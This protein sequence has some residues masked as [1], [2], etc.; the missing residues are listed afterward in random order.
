MSLVTVRDASFSYGT[1]QIFH[2][3]SFSV[4]KGEIFC[5]IGPNGCGKTTL[6]D[7]VLGFH[8]FHSGVF[9]LMGKDAAGFRSGR[10]ARLIA[11]VPQIHER[12]FPYLVR[13]V[14]TMGRSAH[15][16][17]FESPSRKDR[18][19]AEEA[20]ERI[21]IRHL[22]DRP[23]TQLSGGELQLV[24]IARALVQETPIIIM[25]EPTAHLDFRYE[26]VIMEVITELV[27]ERQLSV[28]MATH[29][30]NHAFYFQSK[31]IQTS[32]ALFSNGRFLAV[33]DPESIMDENR[34]RKLYGIQADV[35][36]LT[37]RNGKTMKHII[38]VSTI[39]EMEV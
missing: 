36:S 21:G 10:V 3:I 23:Y 38:P 30:P 16:V 25:D 26:L 37:D 8:H 15:L 19:M 14:V 6:L 4:E 1:R 33:G 24:M 39:K 12:T 2:Q 18:T 32:I 13:E 9:Q 17:F 29:F 35:I 28:I 31:Q 27:K 20:L 11:Y 7:C 34:L 5:L 22:S